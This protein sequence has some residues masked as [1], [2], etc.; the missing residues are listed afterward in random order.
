MPTPRARLLILPAAAALL[1]ALLPERGGT[2]GWSLFPPLLAILVAVASGRLVWGLCLALFSGALIALPTDVPV[3]VWPLHALYMAAIDFVWTPLRDSFQLFILGFTASLIGMVRV[4]SLAGGTR[5]IAEALVRRAASARSTRLA[6]ALLGLAIFFDDYANTIVVG[7][8]MRPITDRFRISREKLAYLVDSTAAPVAGVAI[9]STWIGFEVGLFGDAMDRLGTGISGYELF[10]RALPARFY[11]LLT[12]F[13]LLVSTLMRRDY[14][15]M[16][17]AERRARQHNQP[18]AP[19]AQ[20]MTG[21]AHQV[22]DHPDI[23]GHW[24]VAALPVGL[25]I[26]GVL[27]G[28]HWD[29][30]NAEAVIAARGEHAFFS[31]VYWT[32]VFSNA[33]GAKVMFLSSLAGSGL[34]FVFARTR[35]SLRD[36][37]RPLAPSTILRTWVSGITGFSYALLILVLAW[38]IKEMCQAVHTSDYLIGAL[39][40]VL[41]PRF[42]PLLVFGLAAAVA[43]SIGTSW[44][45]MALLLPTMLPVAHQMGDIT[46]VILVAAAVLDGAI[47][48]D[49]CSPISDTTVLSSIAASCDHIAHVRTQAPYAITTMCIAAVCGYLGSTLLYSTYIG[50]G[51]GMLVVVATLVIVG[52]D[53]DRTAPLDADGESASP[54][55]P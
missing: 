6:T 25:V 10:F 31:R 33:D 15:P 46:L 30:R 7:T 13:F 47:F 44:T 36:G 19:G 27:A 14:G 55:L 23:A 49:H 8:T 17:R 18:L 5:G 24:A 37:S 35:R 3:Y 28:M 54:S 20:P 26:F 42:L 34:A 9:I 16:L 51:L 22:P 4:V 43:F 50:L 32:A 41:D 53:P 12:L 2:D 45:T 11:C 21:D 40:N 39:E 38:G 1:C 52:H 48:G 29:A